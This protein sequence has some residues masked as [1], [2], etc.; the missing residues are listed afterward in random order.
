MDPNYYPSSKLHVVGSVNS[1][2]SSASIEDS[3]EELVR[4]HGEHYEFN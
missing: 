1:G 2:S 4:P 3:T